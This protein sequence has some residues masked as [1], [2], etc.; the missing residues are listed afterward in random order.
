MQEV[1]KDIKGYEGMY[2]VSN[3]GRVKSFDRYDKHGALWLGKILSNK[4]QKTGYVNVKFS[5]DGKRSVKL[6]HR[7]VAEAFI[8]NIENKPE[9]NHKDGNKSNNKVSNLEWVTSREN[10]LHG[11]EKGLIKYNKEALA[12]GQKKSAELMK[13]KVRQVS[14]DGESL[15]EFNSIKEAAETIGRRAA[16]S[17]ISAVCSH[18]QKTAYGYKWE[19]V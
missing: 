17:S 12:R 5:V 14:I 10:T 1:W 9:V 16:R 8:P 7:L 18:K 13:R 3:F 19:Y 11:I 2:Q 6:V 4:P 15:R